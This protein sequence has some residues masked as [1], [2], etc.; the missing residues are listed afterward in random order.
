MVALTWCSAPAE[1]RSARSPWCS[2]KP[3][4]RRAWSISSSKRSPQVL[5][6]ADLLKYKVCLVTG[7]NYTPFGLSSSSPN[8]AGSAKNLGQAFLMLKSK[9][10]QIVPA[11]LEGA[12]GYRLLGLADYEQ[13]GLSFAAKPDR[14]NATQSMHFAVSA[15]HPQAE[16]L[17]TMLNEGLEQL[18]ASGAI[19]DLS[20][21]FG[22][23][24]LP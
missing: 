12:I 17:V 19:R 22:L 6:R 5:K 2:R 11:R 20:D 9:R 16:A 10:C 7:V 23:A 3:C 4:I 8:I 24:Q 1:A 18:K 15:K 13:L 21:R 14:P